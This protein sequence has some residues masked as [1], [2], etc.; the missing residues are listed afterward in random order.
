MREK[1]M[2][3]QDFSKKLTSKVYKELR[4]DLERVDNVLKSKRSDDNRSSLLLCI[5]QDSLI[6][7]FKQKL[8]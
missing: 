7:F 2:R 6:Y 1:A 8:L 4:V 5:C 3:A